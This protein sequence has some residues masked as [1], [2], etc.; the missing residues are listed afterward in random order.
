MFG[1]KL[2]KLREEKGLKQ[3]E[4]ASI[5]GIGRT[6]LS[7]YELNNRE[8]DLDILNKIADFFN[9]SVDFLLGRT[10]IRNRIEDITYIM[11]NG[12]VET[13]KE[14]TEAFVNSIIQMGKKEGLMNDTTELKS[15]DVEEIIEAIKKNGESFRKK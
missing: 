15:E 9:V 2:K 14:M 12:N 5:L 6:T 4:L 1:E 10:S 13:L 8:P 11:K 7:H 3:S